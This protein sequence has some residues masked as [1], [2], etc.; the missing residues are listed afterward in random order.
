VT[1]G[2]DAKGKRNPGLLRKLQDRWR[3]LPATIG[4]ARAWPFGAGS[5][6]PTG[7]GIS[8]FGMHGG[9]DVHVSEHAILVLGIKGLVRRVSRWIC[10]TTLLY[11]HKEKMQGYRSLSHK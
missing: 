9:V 10:E 8:H 2:T 6:F 1:G 7:R 5:S 3:D 4:V 11:L